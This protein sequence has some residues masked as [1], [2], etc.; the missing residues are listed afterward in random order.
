MN[1]KNILWGVV[2]I[3]I[4][5]LF[6]LKNMGMI[7]FNWGII[8]QLWPLLLILW[9]ISLIP[10]KDYIKLII[11]IVAIVAAL[12]II[13][14]NRTNIYSGWGC[15]HIKTEWKEQC[16]D[17]DY[18]STIR[19]ASIQLDAVAGNFRIEG[20]T[21]KLISFDNKGFLGD[22]KIFSSGIDSSKEIRIVLEKNVVNIN[23]N[24]DNNNSMVKLNQN[25]LWDI[26]VDAG[27]ANLYLDLSMYKIKSVKVEG[28][29]SKI[30]IKFGEKS[31]RVKLDIEAG[32]SS[33]NILIPQAS[34]CEVKSD[35]VLS[36]REMPG[37]KE[38][39]EDTFQTDNFIANPN[40]IFV[41][42]DAAL[43]KLNVQKY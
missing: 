15:Q 5:F 29:M 32:A 22:Y 31:E 23:G 28:G 3:G 39:S 9:G 14:Q 6:I 12:L 36:S 26:S 1:Y 18:D 24:T 38:V 20:I 4:G 27:M 41:S 19:N 40:K 43:S 34:G 13:G 7:H 8:L 10:V 30:T 37:F 21:D 33:V 17:E 42:I 11:S 2:L 35:N 25:P 16:L